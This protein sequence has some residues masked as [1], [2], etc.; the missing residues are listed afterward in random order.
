MLTFVE[1]WLCVADVL[2]ECF[3]FALSVL[4]ALKISSFHIQIYH[5]VVAHKVGQTIFG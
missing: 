2:F 4:V 3:H 5:Q 1:H